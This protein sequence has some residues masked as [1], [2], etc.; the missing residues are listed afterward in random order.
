MNSHHFISNHCDYIQPFLFNNIT[1]QKKYLC[2]YQS[3]L[4]ESLIQKKKT[5]FTSIYKENLLSYVPKS[6]LTK[7]IP[8]KESL[9]K[10]PILGKY[11][12]HYLQLLSRPKISSLP[13]RCILRKNNL[14]KALYYLSL[15][16]GVKEENGKKIEYDFCIKENIENCSTTITCDSKEQLVYP[17]EIFKQCSNNNFKNLINEEKSFTILGEDGGNEIDKGNKS[18]FFSNEQD[19]VSIKNLIYFLTVGKNKKIDIKAKLQKFIN[20]KETSNYQ[21]NH[22]KSCPT[23]EH[24]KVQNLYSTCLKGR[25]LLKNPPGNPKPSPLD[26]KKC[27]SVR[28]L[29]KFLNEPKKNKISLISSIQSCK[30]MNFNLSQKKDNPNS[31][32]KIKKINTITHKAKCYSDILDNYCNGK[33]INSKNVLKKKLIVKDF[34][35]YLHS[36]K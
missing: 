18:G 21:I 29:T 13:I 20:E 8:L 10:I 1:N 22:K 9:D 32:Q 28:V 3:L 6:Y 33:F 5:H 34:G 4:I 19:K 16:Y 23:L 30:K 31:K 7:F 12:K 26:N 24:K 2:N 14:Q 11:Y 15:K 36:H 35:N 17:I 25:F 27:T